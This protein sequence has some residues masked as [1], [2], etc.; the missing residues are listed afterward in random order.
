MYSGASLSHSSLK[1]LRV[2]PRVVVRGQ[3]RAAATPTTPDVNLLLL[4][5]L[6]WQWLLLCRPGPSCRSCG[7][8]CR[9][10]Q[11]LWPSSLTLT[12]LR[13]CSPPTITPSSGWPHWPLMLAFILAALAALHSQGLA[14]GAWGMATRLGVLDSRGGDMDRISWKCSGVALVCT[15][16]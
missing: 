9:L 4:L 14:A 3:N 10:T 13:H 2:R 15:N 16:C 7:A 11:A 8:W 5:L 6:L 1:P 12:W